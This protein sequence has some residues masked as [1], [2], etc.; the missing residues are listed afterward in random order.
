MV[1]ELE[2]PTAQNVKTTYINIRGNNENNGWDS[3]KIRCFG[4]IYSKDENLTQLRVTIDTLDRFFRSKKTQHA[5]QKKQP[6]N[7]GKLGYRPH[8]T[9]DWSMLVFD[10]IHDDL[11]PATYGIGEDGLTVQCAFDIDNHTGYKPARPRVLAVKSHIEG[12]G[13]QAV[14]VASGSQDSYHVHIPILRTPIGTSHE[15]LKTVLYELKQ[16]HKDLEWHDT[17]TFPKQSNKDRVF[18]NALKLPLAINNKTGERAKILG[19]DLEPVDVVFITKVIELREP[20]KEAEKVGKRMYLPAKLSSHGSSTYTRGSMRPCIVSALTKQLEGSEGND[21]RV[22]VVCEALASG[23]GRDEIIGMFKGQTDFDE[24]ITAKYI[25]YI[26]SRDYHPWK[27]ETIQDRCSS[28]VDCS[29]CPHN[30]VTVEAMVS[31]E[32]SA[33]SNQA[34]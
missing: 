17:E 30:P 10:M 29:Q 8:I 33:E 31:T 12:L 16:G 18:G 4:A 19:D 21:M 15:F 22:V 20:E 26:K 2:K 24:A 11:T 9:E 13:A 3:A 27:C 6:D 1:Y 5:E 25:D 28:F 14:V 23:K 34:R 7:K 32:S